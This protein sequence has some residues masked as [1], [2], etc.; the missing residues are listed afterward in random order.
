MHFKSLVF[1]R[2]MQ[3][4][5][6]CWHHVNLQTVKV[7]HRYHFSLCT[8]SVG[9]QFCYKWQ[10]I[11]MQVCQLCMHLYQPPIQRVAPK[12]ARHRR[13]QAEGE[14][15]DPLFTYWHFSIVRVQGYWKKT[16][17]NLKETKWLCTFFSFAEISGL[18]PSSL[19]HY[20][21]LQDCRMTL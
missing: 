15:M 21:H 2:L 14:Q 19:M 9:C 18:Q 17:E 16:C 11:R 4:S 20:R 1:V 5:D 7:I 8:G 6:I 13:R 12:R 10:S 3:L